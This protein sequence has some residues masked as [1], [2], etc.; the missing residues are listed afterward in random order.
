MSFSWRFAL[1]FM[2]ALPIGLSVSYKRFVGGSSGM[3]I[4]PA[5]YVGNISYYGTFAPPGLE[6]LGQ[7]TGIS[8][9]TN[10]TLDFATATAP[11]SWEEQEPVLPSEPQ[12][13]GYNVLLL[14]NTSSALLDMPQASYVN[15]VQSKLA[16]GESWTATAPV[17]G[18]V[19]ILSGS[20]Q[21]D[22]AGWNKTFMRRCLLE[23]YGP[24]FEVDY[25][26]NACLSTWSSGAYSHNSM[27]NDWAL[28]LLS[29]DSPGNQS[30]QWIGLV[31]DFGIEYIS[32]CWVFSEYARLYDITRRQCEGTWL[33]TRGRIQLLAG[34][35]DSI[36]LSEEKQYPITR[37]RLFLGVWYTQPLLEFLG[38]FSTTR[39][40][41]SWDGPYF[42]TAVAAMLWSRIVAMNSA[43][44]LENEG[45]EII[46]TSTPDHSNLTY[47]EVG[48]AYPVND[49][50]LYTRPTLIKS[51]WLYLVLSIQPL[52]LLI[53]LGLTA[54]L[55]ATPLDKGFNLIA[56]LS[57]VNPESLRC[58]AG[59]SLSGKLKKELTL[60]FRP[61]KDN[62]KNVIQ[63]SVISSLESVGHGEVEH[64]ALYH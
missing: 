17:L 20:K 31:P 24:G 40:E 64:D 2:L 16:S 56:I 11:T 63:Y 36:V 62:G 61:S 53:V 30:T 52:L 58:L 49:T 25:C 57:G 18:T 41:S 42:A 14:S 28:Q 27:L 37:S 47:D 23:L 7:S 59:A 39:N 1:S 21:T 32:N 48:L 45:R 10:A 35:C 33:I 60:D 13:Y 4:D 15:A 34:S 12:A 3:L 51:Y 44:K 6:S 5:E 55:H 43:T 19:A 46:W 50:V 54:L 29:P 9:F 26:K 8:M 38:P 22:P